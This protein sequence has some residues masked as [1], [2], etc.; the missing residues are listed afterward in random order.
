M[1]S[2]RSTRAVGW[3]AVLGL[4]VLL[5]GLACG[6]G[7][8]ARQRL[9][10]TGD[11]DPAV[12]AARAWLDVFSTRDAERLIQITQLPL[13]FAEPGGL[14]T[15]V[16]KHCDA[17]IG[18]TTRLERL[19]GCLEARAPELVA[20]FG[21]A[22][23]LKLEPTDRTQLRPLLSALLGPARPGEHLVLVYFA[24]GDGAVPFE[25]VLLLVPEENGPRTLVSGLAL[26]ESFVLR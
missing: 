21:H 6:T 10:R 5:P 4:V 14:G 22:G 23:E 12:A 15:E 7:H 11:A 16:S 24:I 3:R 8:V 9:A 13:T 19:I 20:R 1:R 2:V 18:D 17:M 25:L 26:H